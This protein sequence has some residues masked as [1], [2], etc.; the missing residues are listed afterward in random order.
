[1]RNVLLFTCPIF[2]QILYVLQIFF[3]ITLSSSSVGADTFFGAFCGILIAQLQLLNR[4]LE[5]TKRIEVNR[6][7]ILILREGVQYHLKL[8]K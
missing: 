7:Y 8:I 4:K 6:D 1:M 3:I 2:L 5:N